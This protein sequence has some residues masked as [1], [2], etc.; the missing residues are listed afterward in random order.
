LAIPVD[1]ARDHI[2]GPLDAPITLLEYGDYE[3]PDCGRAYPMLKQLTA[4]FGDRLRF[5]FR[6]FPL[7]TIHSH[8]S[9][10]AQAAEAA[11][12]QGKFWPMHDLLY[13]HQAAL[14]TPDLTHYALRLGLEVYKFEQT[15]DAGLFRRRV[16]QD[17][18]SGRQSGVRGT[19]TLFINE[20]RYQGPIE[21]E[22]IA[23]A[24]RSAG[25]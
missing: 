14:D 10:A 12:A 16:E 8:A 20:Q 22:A 6:H 9:M 3:C 13:Q 4:R 24:I 2:L 25:G 1:P 7:Y 19:P 15:L 18:D 11:A 5:V 23:E 21:V 17:Y